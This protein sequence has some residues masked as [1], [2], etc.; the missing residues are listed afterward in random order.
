MEV[1][2]DA[3]A[4]DLKREGDVFEVLC[5]PAKFT[6]VNDALAKAKIPLASAAIESLPKTRVDADT[7][8]ALRVLKLADALEEHDDVQKVYTNLNLTEE[9]IA[10]ASK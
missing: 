7:E 4:D 5:D 2:L 1:V 9:V 8:S 3:G 10:A 6:A